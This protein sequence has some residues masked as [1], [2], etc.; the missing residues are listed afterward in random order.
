MMVI[1]IKA[2]DK[3]TGSIDIQ[4][5]IYLKVNG[6]EVKDLEKDN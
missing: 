3:A 4:T 6:W 5:E 1:S 2:I